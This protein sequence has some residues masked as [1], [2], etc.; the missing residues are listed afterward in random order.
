MK[1]IILAT[2]SVILALGL[3]M[4]GFGCAPAPSPTPKKTPTPAPA[5]KPK[6]IHWLGQNAYTLSRSYKSI[7]PYGGTG[8]YGKFFVDWVKEATN[9]RLV[10]DLKPP[11]AVVSVGEMFKAVS[12]G[13][14]DFAGLYY[15]GF[16]TGIMPEANVEIGPPFAWQSPEEHYDAFYNRGLYEEFKKLY[17]EHNIYPIIFNT[18]DIYHFGTTFPI[19]SPDAIKGK[20]M[21]ALGIYGD[22]V[23]ALGGSATTIPWAEL[24]MSLKR[25]VIDGY[26]GGPAGLK[27]VKLMEVLDYYVVKPNTNV[28]GCN[29]L[30]NLDSLNAL[31]KDIKDMIKR[32]S[33]RVILRYAQDYKMYYRYALAEATEE[34]G[35]KQVRWSK[36]DSARVRKMAIEKL[37][38]KIAAKS[39]KCAEL[40][41]IVKEQMR[42]L[43]KI[44]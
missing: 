7:K 28:I 43:G 35:L 19:D 5:P 41:E 2:A 13:T 21:R 44:E 12:K 31:P 33:A 15:A 9:G 42:E 25:G 18:N 26:L 16:Y 37:W 40:M 6:V 11:G 23:E 39:P 1:R 32:D 27:D 29:F 14:L 3:V 20:K 17:A 8:G 30:I 24:Y 36:E 38:P 34:Y 10:I 4:G 22:Y